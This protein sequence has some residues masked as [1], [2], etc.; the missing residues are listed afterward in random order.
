MC[1]NKFMLIFVYNLKLNKMKNLEITLNENY[2]ITFYD[3]NNKYR[4]SEKK[5]FRNE[6]SKKEYLN[7]IK[8]KN[9]K[10]QKLGKSYNEN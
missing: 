5:L 7:F 6:E 2:L 3:E 8:G 1:V 4:F 9:V 10:V